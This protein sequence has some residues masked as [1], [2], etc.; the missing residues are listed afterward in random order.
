ME[1]RKTLAAR[2]AELTAL[3]RD[4]WLWVEARRLQT[5]FV[6]PRSYAFDP[7]DKCPETFWLKN[8]AVRLRAFGAAGLL[9][10][11]RFRYPRESL[12]RALPVLLWAEP[13]FTARAA[14][15]GRWLGTVSATWR[16]AVAAYERLWARFN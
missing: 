12:L 8:A 2:H 10:A 11:D 7:A 13:E 3:G 15:L 14:A 6:D 5:S 4:L 16:D 9:A 1:S